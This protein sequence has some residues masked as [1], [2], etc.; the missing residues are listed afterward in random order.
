MGRVDTIFDLDYEP[1]M[2]D[3]LK[4]RAR[5][6]GL[7]EARFFINDIPFSSFD[8]GGQRTERRKWIQKFEGVTAVIF[9]AALNHFCT[10]LFEDERKNGMLESL[11]LFDEIV[12]AKWFRKTAIILFL[13]KNDIFEQRLREGL[14]LDVA[15][16]DEWTGPNYLD[17][18][19]QKED[20]AA[21]F[22]KCSQSA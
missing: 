17:Q 9:V 11:E 13:N 6:T 18:P 21:W 10:V 15:F 20:D 8:A 14:T 22:K 12:N 7:I 5:T 16:P 19:E 4:C 3:V 1:S 2:E